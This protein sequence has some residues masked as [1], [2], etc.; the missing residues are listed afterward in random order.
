MIY[1]KQIKMMN[2]TYFNPYTIACFF[3]PFLYYHYIPFILF[4]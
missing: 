4:Y 1:C 2:F 3:I